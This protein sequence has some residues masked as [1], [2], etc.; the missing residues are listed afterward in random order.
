MS[1]RRLRARFSR[2]VL[3]VLLAC[4]GVAGI[5][6]VIAAQEAPDQQAD[7]G[8][9]VEA[10]IVAQR[11]DDDRVEF[12]LQLRLP[13]EP[14]SE[15]E[16]PELR[17]IPPGAEV[18]RWLASSPIVLTTDSGAAAAG[19]DIEVRIAAQRRSNDRIEFALQQREP[20][21]SWGERLLPTRRFLPPG[22]DAGRWLASSPLG[23]QITPE[24]TDTEPVAGPAGPDPPGA[25]EP[26]NGGPTTK[27]DEQPGAV[28]VSEDMLDVDMIDVH[29]GETVNLR[30]V[31]NGE[32]PLLFWLWSPY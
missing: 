12:G 24:S 5:P 14:W 27:G 18:G 13:G 15:R 28:Q 19:T 2:A 8:D 7:T 10:R 26:V 17:F 22:T 3:A 16:L 20:R 21:E 31:V 30:S 9:E 6:A 23:L 25:E 32:T 1:S 4:L 11:L 29:T